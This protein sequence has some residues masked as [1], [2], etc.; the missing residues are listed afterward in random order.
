MILGCWGGNGVVSGFVIGQENRELSTVGTGRR[1]NWVGV[2]C[3]CSALF[4][5]RCYTNVASWD[6]CNNSQICS[7]L[8]HGNS[9]FRSESFV[10]LK[11]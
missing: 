8:I 6:I 1:G 7:G 3:C 10:M 4:L 9:L 2:L 11:T 5:S